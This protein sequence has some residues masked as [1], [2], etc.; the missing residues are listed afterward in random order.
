MISG[1]K[2]QDSWV[3]LGGSWKS[4]LGGSSSTGKYRGTTSFLRLTF[5]LAG[6]A[7]EPGAPSLSPKNPFILTCHPTAAPDRRLQVVLAE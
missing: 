3:I 2:F 5:P 4:F 1:S 6:L 7:Y